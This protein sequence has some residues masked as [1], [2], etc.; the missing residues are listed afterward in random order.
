MD[1][2]TKNEAVFF[3]DEWGHI[4]FNTILHEG[5]ES[6]AVQ[7]CHPDFYG[8]FSYTITDQAA[9]ETF[10]VPESEVWD[11]CTDYQKMTFNYTQCNHTV[12]YSRKLQ[13][14][15]SRSY[16]VAQENSVELYREQ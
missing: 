15:C 11:V 3:L 13:T 16:P 5:F 10:C 4:V 1:N 7:N 12:A 14:F 6:D 8:E 9:N 2:Y